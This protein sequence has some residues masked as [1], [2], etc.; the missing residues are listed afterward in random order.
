MFRPSA[1]IVGL[2]IS[3]RDS[4]ALAM[5]YNKLRASD[6]GSRHYLWPDA[7]YLL[8]TLGSRDE[9][10]RF[11]VHFV[12]NCTGYLWNFS[13]FCIEPIVARIKSEDSLASDLINHVK[14]EKASLPKLLA[15]ANLMDGELQ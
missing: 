15:L 4:S 5:E 11:L 1:G 13:P 14:S 2:S 7:A 9:L 3:W 8:S 6:N 10:R 12:H